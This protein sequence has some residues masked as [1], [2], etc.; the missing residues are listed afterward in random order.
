VVNAIEVHVSVVFFRC[1]TLTRKL[2][3]VR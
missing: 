1:H 2:N 3:V